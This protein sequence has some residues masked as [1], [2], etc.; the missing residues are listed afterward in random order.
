MKLQEACDK[1]NKLVGIKFSSLFSAEEMRDIIIAKGKT[2]QLL[3]LALG[4]N[5]SSADLDFEDGELKTNKCDK[6][7]KPYETVFITQISA[8]IDE[9][10]AKK[11]FK[12]QS[13]TRKSAISYMY[14][15]AK[16]VSRKIG[17]FCQ[18][19]TLTYPIQNTPR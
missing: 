10:L 11:E 12:R 5:L 15:F 7:G 18:A 19:S 8:M 1:L 4:M 13:F 3:E 2:G 9:L 14:Q 17:S 6:N 16:T